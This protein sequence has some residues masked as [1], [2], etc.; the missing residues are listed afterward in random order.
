MQIQAMNRQAEIDAQS[1][2]FKIQEM[3]LKHRQAMQPK[4]VSTKK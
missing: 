3:E 1:H 2:V 4:P